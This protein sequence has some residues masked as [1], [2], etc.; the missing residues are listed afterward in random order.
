MNWEP[1]R[2]A[3]L[4]RLQMR[5]TSIRSV[6]R[7]P[8]PPRSAAPRLSEVRQCWWGHRKVALQSGT[9]LTKEYRIAGS[10]GVNR[11][12][13]RER[14]RAELQRA[15]TRTGERAVSQ[16]L[17]PHRGVQTTKLAVRRAAPTANVAQT[18]NRGNMSHRRGA[19]IPARCGAV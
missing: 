4:T 8:G 10:R 18:C 1:Q 7:L 14:E 11:E 12:P 19:L 16:L 9:W 2:R 15:T 6:K 13:S 5:H 3:V 17:E